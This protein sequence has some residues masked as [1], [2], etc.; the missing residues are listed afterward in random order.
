[1][2]SPLIIYIIIELLEVVRHA[3]IISVEKHSPRKWLSVLLRGAAL[4]TILYFEPRPLGYSAFMYFC[5][6]WW[7]HDYVLNLVLEKSPIWYLNNTGPID[8]FQ[9]G[10]V[11]AGGWFIWK[12]ILCFGSVAMYF[13]N[14]WL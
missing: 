6:G 11:G 4:I 2:K 12:T 1:M 5:I 8:K 10:F 9:N 13:V 7:I 14:D 3:W